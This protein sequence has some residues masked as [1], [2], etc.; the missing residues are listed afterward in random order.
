[1]NTSSRVTSPRRLRGMRAA[2]RWVENGGDLQGVPLAIIENA[3]A[4]AADF[5]VRDLD[6]AEVDRA[7]TSAVA[8]AVHDREQAEA[9]KAIASTREEDRLAYLA[10]VRAGILAT[11]GEPP[12]ERR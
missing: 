10:K 11:R 4:D 1:M 7:C 2:G 12:K 6:I 3:C 5:L 9:E 8:T